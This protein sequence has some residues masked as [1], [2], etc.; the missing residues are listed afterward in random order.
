MN[1]WDELK[2]VHLASHSS[3]GRGMGY[4]R[5]KAVLRSEQ[6]GDGMYKGQVSGSETSCYDTMINIHRPRQSTCTCPFAAGRRVICKHMVALYFFH[7]PEQA[8]AVLAAWEEEEAEKEA[9]YQEWEAEY[10]EVRQNKVEEVT[11]YVRSLTDE[12]VRAELITALLKEFDWHYPD[13][14]EEYGYDDDYY[15]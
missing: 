7:F 2:L 5:S 10:S 11:A 8:D 4:H 15:F 14:E 13:Y 3:F 1:I 6:C 12:Q 9:H